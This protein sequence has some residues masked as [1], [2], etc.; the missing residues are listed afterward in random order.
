MRRHCVLLALIFHFTVSSCSNPQDG[1][2]FTC[3]NARTLHLQST[4]N[5]VYWNSAT[6][7]AVEN[8]TMYNPGNPLPDSTQL[9][10]ATSLYDGYVNEYKLKNANGNCKNALQRFSCVLAFPE[11]PITSGSVSYF[12]PCELQCSQVNAL[13]STSIACDSFTKN[14]CMIYIPLGYFLLDPAQVNVAFRICSRRNKSLSSFMCVLAACM[15]GWLEKGSLH[16]FA[17]NIRSCV[18]LLGGDG[19]IVELFNIREV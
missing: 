8:Y 18:S 1:K 7:L 5:F 2:I 13:C 6:M 17:A 10:F 12:T 9:S 4:C 15:L 16:K 11:C 19:I 3:A 14:D